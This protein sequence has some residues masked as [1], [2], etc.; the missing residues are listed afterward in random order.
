MKQCSP[1]VLYP[2]IIPQH[3]HHAQVIQYQKRPRVVS[4]V[5]M[6]QSQKAIPMRSRTGRSVQDVLASYWTLSVSVLKLAL[7]ELHL[8]VAGAKVSEL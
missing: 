8:F 3:P 6:H 1:P 5:R 4:N 2:H 7:V